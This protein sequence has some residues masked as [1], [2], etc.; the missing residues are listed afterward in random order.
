[1]YKKGDLKEK[2]RRINPLTYFYFIR[3]PFLSEF[4]WRSGSI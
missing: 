4:L 2:A 3:F 1:M